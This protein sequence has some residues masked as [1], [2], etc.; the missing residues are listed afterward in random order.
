VRLAF[1]LARA[2]N[3]QQ[4]YWLFWDATLTGGAPDAN[5]IASR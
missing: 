1:R 4:S 2:D 3:K 5:V